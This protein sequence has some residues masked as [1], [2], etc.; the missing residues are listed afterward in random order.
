[1]NI[2]QWFKI[3]TPKYSA[4]VIFKWL[5]RAWRGNQLQ[6]ILNAAIGL[7]SV[8]VSL[9]QVWA[10]QHAIDVASG[11]AEGSIYWSVGVMAL[12]V[13]CGFVLR[14]CSIWVRNILGIKAQNRMQQ[15]MLDRILRS[16]WTG[17]ESHHSGDVLN[18]L[19]Q[20]V[21]TVV[22]FL[23]ETIPNTISVV[24]MF[25][26]AF[27]YLFSMD[28]VLAFV[29]V[30]IIP[31]FVLLS[32]LY[33]GQMRRLTRQ[34]RD[35]D[36]KVQSVLQETIQHRMLIKTL[37]SD[38]I[39]VD[40]LESTQSELRHRVVKRTAFSVVSNFILNAGFSVGYLIAFLW[41]ALRMADQTLTFGGMTAFLQL[42]NRIQ[43]PARDLTRLAPV[44]V[45]VFTAAER[46]M[47]LEENPLEEQGD[48]IPLTAPCGVRLEHIT[49]AYDD[50]D[51]NVIE[52]LDFDFYP[53]SCTAVLGETG[54][55]KT[56]LIRLILALLHPNEGK[57]ILYNQQEQ[58][59]LS[60]LMR[61]NFVYVPQGNTLMSGTIRDN[62]RLGKLN[63][64]EEEIKAALEM[65][66]ASFVMELPDG[67]DTVCTEAGGGLSEGQAQRISIA[68]ALLRNRPIMLF[69]EATSA[70]DPETERQLLHNILS[71]HD[72]TV[73]FITHR[74]AVVDYC[75]QTLH[76]QKQ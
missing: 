47:E 73:I 13:L 66:C 27:L 36:S 40:R 43:G 16:E 34:V 46:L 12:L 31:V 3:P 65:S 37:E 8:V 75:D 53:G 41:A 32:K 68:R 44:F 61:C 23:T 15:R 70:L 9:A 6:A 49:Y 21:G 71:N 30:G 67:L 57:V 2:R 28:K 64:T 58:K 38:S 35:S 51:S 74:P 5:W 56:T 22:S 72:K 54:A 76:L 60:P 55:G 50:G 18:R 17:K 63:A 33:I 62:L 52:Q 1:M 10:V 69:D 26:G 48:P 59:E 29:I 45:G 11:H 14:I 20:D 24:A 25:V 19:E 39:M 7:L 4:R 42:V